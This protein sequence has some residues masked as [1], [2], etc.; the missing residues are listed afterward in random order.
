MALP[1][2]LAEAAIMKELQHPNLVQLLGV[3]TAEAPY[4]IICEFMSRGNLLDFLR[5]TDRQF[6]PQ[7]TILNMAIQVASGMAYLE[8]RNF[9]HRCGINFNTNLNKSN[10]F[11]IF[12]FNFNIKFKVIW[13]PE[14]VLLAM[15]S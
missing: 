14:I 12:Y 9:I 7:S 13:P 2:F 1:D 10:S 6:L 15:N 8:S 5:Q 11:S 3:C 4:F